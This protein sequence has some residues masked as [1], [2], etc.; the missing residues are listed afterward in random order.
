[1]TDRG[2]GCWESRLSGSVRGWS[3]TLAMDNILW[4]R[5]ETR[6]QTENTNLILRPGKSPAYSKPHSQTPPAR[7]TARHQPNR[8][9]TAFGNVTGSLVEYG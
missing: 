7:P 5:R 2:A 9:T 6:R 4:H 1:M 3:A 8:E